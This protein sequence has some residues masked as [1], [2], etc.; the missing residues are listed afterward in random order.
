MAAET[1]RLEKQDCVARAAMKGS[2]PRACNE[3]EEQ[4]LKN[5]LQIDASAKG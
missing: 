5:Q 3:A 2:S 1:L 4:S